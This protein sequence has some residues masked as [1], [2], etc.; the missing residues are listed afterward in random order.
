MECFKENI[1]YKICCVE[2]KGEYFVIYPLI[3]TKETTIKIENRFGIVNYGFLNWLQKENVQ[4]EIIQ[5]ITSEILNLNTNYNDMKIKFINK[6]QNSNM[7]D[8]PLSTEIYGI[9][10]HIRLIEEAISYIFNI[11]TT[12][13]IK[14]EYHDF[15]FKI[16][17]FYNKIDIIIY[18]D[19]LVEPYVNLYQKYINKPIDTNTL[20]LSKISNAS[21]SSSIS[22][23][24]ISEI[25]KFLES[26]QKVASNILPV[27]HFLTPTIQ[28]YIEPRLYLP[29]G[30]FVAKNFGESFENVR[31]NDIIIGYYERL[32]NSIDFK[33]KL[34]AQYI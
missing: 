34:R 15:Y 30:W 31:E 33:F 7:L 21:I 8:I 17:H 22:S 4:N 2:N 12:K 13:D 19:T 25:N 3:E 5:N 32:E 6:F 20:L 23:F 14:S 29:T 18:A 24:N 26:K 27:G 1:S 9:D 28:S 11:L 16:I 10:F